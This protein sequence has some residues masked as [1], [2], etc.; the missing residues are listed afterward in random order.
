MRVFKYLLTT[1]F[2]VVVVSGVGF[3]ALRLILL[4]ASTKKLEDSL[5]V[6][7]LSAAR[8]VAST[9]CFELAG[10]NSA[11]DQPVVYQIRF[12]NDT[13]YVLEAVC[14]LNQ[15]N[16][17]ELGANS[18]AAF[19]KKVPG[20]SGFV[21]DES[22]DTGIE[23]EVFGELAQFLAKNAS[24]YVD[25]RL[26]TRSRQIVIENGVVN[27]A[28]TALPDSQQP[29]ATCEGYGFTCCDTIS[30]VGSG[31]QL[32]GAG[33]CSDNCFQQCLNRPVVLSFA[34][35]PFF[36][37]N[38]RQVDVA[39]G[40]PITFAFVVDEKDTEDFEV[41][42][43]FGDGQSETFYARQGQVVHEYDCDDPFCSYTAELIV[44]DP[45][46]LSSIETPISEIAVNVSR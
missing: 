7:K 10:G 5:E 37:P 23:I 46:G 2:L 20:K 44:T 30:Q 8:N 35:N 1:L 21:W 43:D 14:P 15:S 40:T 9:E 34:T 18:L 28:A 6:L 11:L 12:L 19:V 45:D 42:I 33:Q 29:V 24:A 13:D 25:S 27:T 3:L 38:T 26:I 17:I 16:P 41:V 22:F 4:T 32:A 39:V 31:G 36:N